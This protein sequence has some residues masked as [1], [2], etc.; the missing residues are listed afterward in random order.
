MQSLRSLLHGGDED[1]AAAAATAMSKSKK[2]DGGSLER[3]ATEYGP[4]ERMPDDDKGTTTDN[5]AQARHRQKVLRQKGREWN[6]LFGDD[7]NDDDDFKIGLALNLKKA[8]GGE[9]RPRSSHA[10]SQEDAAASSSN[11]EPG[12]VSIKLFTDFYR[13]DIILAS[14]L[15]L[16]M[17]VE[18]ADEESSSDF[19][20]S[21]EI[22]L[23]DRADVLLEQNW[24]HVNDVLNML[25][26][27]PKSMNETDF[28]RVRPYMLAGHAALWRQLVVLSSLSDPA[29]LSSFKRHAQ[30]ISG[31][32][33]IKRRYPVENASISSVLLPVRQV[34]QR[35]ACSSF[36]RQSEDRLEYFVE[37]VLPHLERTKQKHTMI[38]VPSYFDFVSLRNLLLQRQETA[39]GLDFVS[40]TEYS[41]G[42][43]VSRGR[44]RFL[45]GRKPLMLYTGRAHFFLR[46]AIKGVRH[47]IFFGLPTHASFY[48]EHVNRLNEGLGKDHAADQDEANSAGSASS[49]CLALY[50]KYD[51][52]ALERIVGSSNCSRMIKGEKATYLFSSS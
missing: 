10:S 24:D 4:P 40:V 34:F 19:L 47:L 20:S 27:Q 49:S 16:K 42:T 35:V 3:F 44:A 26:Q 29:I 36:T 28:S 15:G 32:A 46:H 21:I 13:S 30:S 45:Q 12:N 50:T 38:F 52:H 51:A 9:K 22:C 7:R 39:G 41:R 33:R 6:E 17:T 31:I 5:A 25:N 43:E 11:S 37:K 1:Q 23:V 8:G 48:A 18:A 14:P 2:E